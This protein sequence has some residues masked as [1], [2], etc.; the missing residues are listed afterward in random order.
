[1]RLG[2]V[3]A[4]LENTVSL[5]QPSKNRICSSNS[6]VRALLYGKDYGGAYR[7]GL[8]HILTVARFRSELLAQRSL[9]GRY[10]DGVAEMSGTIRDSIPNK[11]RNAFLDISYLDNFIDSPVAEK[12]AET[13][14]SIRK[15]YDFYIDKPIAK[16]RSGLYFGWHGIKDSVTGLFRKTKTN[17]VDLDFVKQIFPSYIKIP[18]DASK[19]ELKEFVITTLKKC[20]YSD[21][22]IKAVLERKSPIFYRFV[23]ETELRAVKNGRKVTSAAAYN[24]DGIKTDITNDP[25]YSGVLNKYR[26]TFKINPEWNPFRKG[27]KSAVS[28]NEINLKTWKLFGGYEKKDILCTERVR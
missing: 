7:L 18:E 23:D 14:S 5:L 28:H 17:D 8:M 4:R 3:G 25:N 16:V 11:Y 26:I 6:G 13:A 9:R 15:K 21:K 10:G 27:K 20:N 22:E 19:E 24:I 12:L 2:N 1:M